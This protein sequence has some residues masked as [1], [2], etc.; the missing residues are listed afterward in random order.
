MGGEPL[1]EKAYRNLIFTAFNNY[2]RWLDLFTAVFV[3]ALLGLL[4][5]GRR[6]TVASRAWPA[7]L[8]LVGAYLA[9]PNHS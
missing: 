2:N 6:L 3:I 9:A 8:L 1:L 5:F 7:V 4:F